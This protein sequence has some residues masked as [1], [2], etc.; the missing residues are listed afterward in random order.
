MQF[1]ASGQENAEFLFP[2]SAMADSQG[3]IFI[4]DGN[5]AR[6]SV[7]DQQGSFLFNFASGSEESSVGLPRGL[8]IDHKDRLY[9]VDAIGQ[10]IKVYDVSAREPN[11]LFVFGDFGAE[12]G[13]FNFPNDIS[14]DMT[15]RIYVA[16]RE[17]NRVQVW[18]Y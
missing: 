2:N 14:L 12:D 11:F 7:W 4:S 5:N 17:N 6:I 1:G 13:L 15:G 10:D 16:D 3:R 9:V 8:Y 18:S